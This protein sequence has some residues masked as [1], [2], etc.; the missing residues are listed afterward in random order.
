M[1][2]WLRT[3]WPTVYT[4]TECFPRAFRARLIHIYAGRYR[5]WI[6]ITRHN[7][8]PPSKPSAEALRLARERFEREQKIPSA[9]KVVMP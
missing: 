7:M 9:R 5:V 3:R 2:W 6:R 8:P 1:M 4:K